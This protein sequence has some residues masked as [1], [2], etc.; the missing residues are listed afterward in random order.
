MF[1][2]FIIEHSIIST[3]MA[4]V[5]GF[6]SILAGVAWATRKSVI[7]KRAQFE[8]KEK[9]KIESAREAIKNITYLKKEIYKAHSAIT[10]AAASLEEHLRDRIED[11]YI[12]EHT[13]GFIK[14][15]K[16]YLDERI[17]SEKIEY[18]I[19]LLE[20][21]LYIDDGDAEISIEMRKI[22]AMYVGTMGILNFNT[23]N[24]AVKEAKRVAQEMLRKS[25]FTA[26]DKEEEMGDT[27]EN[28]RKKY[29]ERLN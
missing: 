17:E 2:E 16:E 8:A 5:F 28:L 20:D 13:A 12:G 19:A 4:G 25:P 3:L 10:V 15:M 23:N 29:M 24:I 11:E 7:I 9:I 21:D 27:F 1:E 22:K 14:K 18:L 6:L 26:K